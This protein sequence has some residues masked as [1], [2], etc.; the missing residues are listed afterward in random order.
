MKRIKLFL[1]YLKGSYP[2]AFLS[3][4]CALIS[5]GS[6]LAI[7][8]LAGKAINALLD[9]ESALPIAVYLNLILIFIVLGTLFRYAFDYLTAL[10]GQRVVKRMRLAVFAAYQDAPISYIDQNRM[11]D[12]VLRLINDVENVQTGLVSG[13]SALYDGIIAIGFTL[14]FM[15]ILNWALALIVVVLTPIS[16][17]TS[18]KISHFNS[19]HFKGQAKAAGSLTAFTLESLTNSE[20]VATLDLAEEREAAFDELNSSYKEN[21]FKAVFGSSL[22]NPLTRLVNAI[23]NATVIATG[24]IFVI[25]ASS[26]PYWA[27]LTIGALSAFLTYAANYMQPFNE[28]SDVIT[29]IDY[30]WASFERIEKAIHAPKN[31]DQGQ[32]VI[33]GSIDTLKASHLNFSYDPSRLIIQD[34]DLEIFKG[35]R[36][37]LVGPTGCGKTTLINLLLRFYDPQQGAFYANGISTQELQKAPFR[38]H[39][40][41]VL[42]DTWIFSGTV[43]ENIAYAKPSASREEVIAAAKKAQADGFIERLPQGYETKISDSSGLSIGEKQLLCVARV[44]LL[45]PEIVILDEATSNIDIRTESLL[46]KSFAELMKNKTSLVVAHRLSTIVGSD[47]IV[48][49]KDGKII[50]MG[51]HQQL[52]DKQGFYYSLYSAQFH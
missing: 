25:N 10:L 15:A 4:F 5:T 9:Q 16:I 43:Y 48:V 31:A 23:V 7:P 13:F 33:A 6:K 30:A 51:N 20:S 37:A 3:L 2:L 8:L 39:L 46:S 18:K 22:I 34:F 50:E 49:M 38:E 12:L 29:E 28:I 35:H 52:L 17:F 26:L 44:M 45:A 1:P 24:A 47:L 19:V 27:P 40:G 36:I 42:Q 41:M 14:T 11:G 32:Q 21:T